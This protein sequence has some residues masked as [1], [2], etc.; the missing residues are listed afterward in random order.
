MDIFSAIIVLV[1]L[2]LPIATRYGVDPVHLGII[3]LANLEIGYS[4]PPVG[5]NLFIASQRFR[6]PIFVLFRAALPFLAIMLLWLMFVTYV[7][8]ASLWWQSPSVV[9]QSLDQ[10]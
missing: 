3:F 10:L 2:I 7:N 5:M 6:K 8:Q 1:P 9:N 4:T